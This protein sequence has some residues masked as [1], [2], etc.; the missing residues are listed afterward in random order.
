MKKHKISLKTLMAIPIILLL[1]GC[2]EKEDYQNQVIGVWELQTVIE[3]DVELKLPDGPSVMLLFEEN[4]VYRSNQENTI[5]NSG[6]YPCY[7]GAWSVTD[8][9][10]LEMGLN[11]WKLSLS[12]LSSS[13]L[14]DQ[15]VAM[16]LPVRFTILEITDNEM[17]LRIRTFIGDAK[18][19]AQFYEPVLPF[20]T[21][22]NYDSVSAEFKTLKTFVYKFRKKK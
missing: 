7:F 19:T 22:D 21:R 4:G 20:I 9:K 11:S 3:D 5:A 6:V 8:N 1:V 16:F 2:N 18:Y 13:N 17:V 10:W 12:P 14:K 15:W